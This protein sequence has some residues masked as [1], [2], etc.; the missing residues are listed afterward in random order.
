[1]GKKIGLWYMHKSVDFKL[2][3]A[4]K[5]THT[6]FS[7]TKESFRLK[8]KKLNITGHGINVKQFLR[9]DRGGINS[10]FKIV[11]VG[12][13]SPIKD[14]DTLIDAVEILQKN[15]VKVHLDIIGGPGK[16]DQ[17]EYLAG[18]IQKVK[19]KKLDEII[20]FV[21]AVPNSNIGTYLHQADL[22]VNSSQTGSLDKTILE[23]MACGLVVISSNDSSKDVF[24]ENKDKLFFKP[25]DSF[26]LSQ[27]ISRIIRLPSSDRER[28]G[29]DLRR[30]VE[31]NHDLE[32]L[33]KKIMNIYQKIQ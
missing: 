9:K 7:A 8:T 10:F 31:K 23:A 1:M 22:F 4:E 28:I 25:K 3:L 14:Y 5:L 29:S 27:K 6:I 20:N 12:R 13:I 26:D 11:T 33:I 18:L 2:R 15:N 16:L 32:E 17:E 21:G 19:D 24:R 30:K